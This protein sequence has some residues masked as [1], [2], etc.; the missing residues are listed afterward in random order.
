M[1]RMSIIGN[2][3]GDPELRDVGGRQVCSFNVG[4]RSRRK[5][6]ETGRYETEWVR[7]TA[8][9]SQADYCAKY[10]TK[11][12]KIFA[13]GDYNH[14]EFAAKDGGKGFSQELTISAIESLARSEDQTSGSDNKNGGFTEVEDDNLPF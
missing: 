3:G 12:A 7:C 10:L 6:K 13:V 2:L 14:S 4:C 8:W 5:N 11:G 1:I 9:G